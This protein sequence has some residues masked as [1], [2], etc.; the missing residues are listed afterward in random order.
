VAYYDYVL[1]D[2]NYYLSGLSGSVY[3]KGRAALFVTT[4]LSMVRLVIE[5]NQ[6]LDLYCAA[7]SASIAA[8]HDRPAA[9]FR[10]WGLPS[11]QTLRFFQASNFVGVV[12]APS[13][14]AHFDIGGDRSLE[15]SGALVSRCAWFY[16]RVNMHFDESLIR[17]GP[18]Y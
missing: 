17:T 16:G 5:T 14:D 7:G 1:H 18:V 10:F 6:S 11:C 8:Q 15:F 2:W 9:S 3:V 13:A 12:Y 4:S